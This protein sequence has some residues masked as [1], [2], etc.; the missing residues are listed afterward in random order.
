[1]KTVLQGVLFHGGVNCLLHGLWMHASGGGG[2]GPRIN[3]HA[4]HTHEH[5]STHAASQ[6]GAQHST[7]GRTPR[8]SSTSK[9]K[10]Q[11]KAIFSPLLCMLTA[12][13]RGPDLKN[14]LGHVKR[15]VRKRGETR[16]EGARRKK[17][18]RRH[19]TKEQKAKNWCLHA[20]EEKGHTTTRTCGKQRESV[21]KT[22]HAS[23]THF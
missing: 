15:P 17:Q 10:L 23:K 5:Q 9:S 18:T 7:A 11:E 12:G 6:H 3:E 20:R 2:K 16:L 21:H 8:Y 22:M 14:F 1:M 19:T 13:Y 4:R